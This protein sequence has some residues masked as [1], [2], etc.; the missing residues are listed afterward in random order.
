MTLDL[1]GR[2][3]P[4]TVLDL[5]NAVRSVG[6]DGVIE[7]VV[8]DRAGLEDVRAWCEATGS[9]FLGSDTEGAP[10]AYVRRR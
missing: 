9:E 10:R 5:A 2:H 6:G 3:C 4:Y 1:R 7:V 8:D